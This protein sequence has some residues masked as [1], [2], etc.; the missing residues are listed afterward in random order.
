MRR[1]PM[2]AE[3]PKSVK[4]RFAA[5]RGPAA[6]SVM[7]GGAARLLSM[8]L[9]VG[10]NLITARLIWH[11]V[12]DARYGAVLLIT[13]LA[14]L[15]PFADLGVSAP[16][17]TGVASSS[18]LRTDKAV[19]DLLR[20][21]LGTLVRSAGALTM[22]AFLLLVT[23]S[24]HSVLGSGTSALGEAQTAITVV[25]V[26]IALG[27]PMGLGQRVLV[28]L[29]K[30]HLSVLVSLLAPASALGLVLVLDGVSAP[31][32][33]YV[34]PASLSALVASV[35]TFVV[36]DVM[37]GVGLWKLLGHALR[38]RA[39]VGH[40][41]IMRRQALPMF[42]LTIATPISLQTDRIVISHRSTASALSSYALG[43]Q[44]YAPCFGLAIA[45]STA[46]WPIAAKRR[47]EG[48][49]NLSLWRQSIVAFAVGGLLL[50]LAVVTVGPY[51]VAFLS[52]SASHTPPSLLW[53]FGALLLVQMISLP[54]SM[55]LTDDAGLRLQAGLA[56]V[57]AVGNVVLSWF[58]ARPLGAVGPVL[59]SVIFVL[60]CQFVPTTV[61]A[62]RH[63]D[64]RRLASVS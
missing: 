16:V 48:V 21:S 5:L 13:N 1:S 39:P 53:A 45:A 33:C 22:I 54:S 41:A 49:S 15:I 2:R 24:W 3:A 12:G 50:G 47:A 17:M 38:S 32:W 26:V 28:G 27:L 40:L 56:V 10:L 9:S 60:V 7:K 20:G 8:P 35:A 11:S 36:A 46:L 14:T 42:V 19:A 58:L 61:F 57:A 63:L 23:G 43:H 29:G 59:A 37:S 55:M 64:A 44:L 51:A 52:G 30:T 34:L 62:E 18:S 31:S 4:H 6:T 25:C